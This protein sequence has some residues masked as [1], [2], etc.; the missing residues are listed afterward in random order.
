M[1]F[2]YVLFLYEENLQKVE[3]PFYTGS[4]TRPIIINQFDKRQ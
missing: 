3:K 1:D 2:E 4:S